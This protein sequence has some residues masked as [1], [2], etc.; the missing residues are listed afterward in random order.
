M[1]YWIILLWKPFGV[2]DKSDISEGYYSP[3]RNSLIPDVGAS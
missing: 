1:R 3:G 2:T